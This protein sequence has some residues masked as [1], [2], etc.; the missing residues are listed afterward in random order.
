[1]SP[2][3]S[4]V[5]GGKGGLVRRDVALASLSFLG[6]LFAVPTIVFTDGA[7]IVSV[8]LSLIAIGAGLWAIRTQQRPIRAVAIA[9]FAMGA[10][11]LWYTITGWAVSL[12]IAQALAE[13]F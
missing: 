10:L 5:D 7:L 3:P 12:D 2:E 11:S 9:G 8:I 6:G 4:S 1:M 13:L